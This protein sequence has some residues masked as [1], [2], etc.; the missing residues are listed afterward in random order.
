M[1]KLPS[2]FWGFGKLKEV[3][4]MRERFVVLCLTALVLLVGLNG[5]ANSQL[6]D[7][8]TKD[9]VDTTGITIEYMSVYPGSYKWVEVWWKNPVWVSGYDLQL[10][11]DDPH[12][13]RFFSGSP[14]TCDV[15][16][17][18]FPW[19]SCQ[20]LNENCTAV[21]I[22]AGGTQ[23]GPSTES[24]LLFKIATK[25]N[26]I[27]DADTDRSAMIRF[28]PGFCFLFGPEGD[29]LPFRSQDGELFVWWSVPGDANG[30][31]VLNSADV[32]FLIHYL[33]IKGPGPC[34]CEAADCTN[35][36]LINMADVAYLINYLFIY[37]P[38]PVRG[39]AYCP[40]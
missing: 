34:V 15:L 9:D 2:P 6:P 14:G 17:S 33:F 26:C 22:R 12:I 7:L 28:V 38:A 40:H 13:A 23:V 27:S 10:M 39:S 21:R 11:I 19:D 29:L 16:G 24:R 5:S 30:D 35:D 37:G 31:S 36:G 8:S 1:F 20:C 25:F 32:I 3:L 18:P 4:G